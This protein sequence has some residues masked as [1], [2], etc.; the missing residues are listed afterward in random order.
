MATYTRYEYQGKQYHSLYQV[1]QAIWSAEHKVFGQLT[2]DNCESFSVTK[3]QIE[4]PATQVCQP[5]VI[6]RQIKE[7]LM[8]EMLMR[9]NPMAVQALSLSEDTQSYWDYLWQEYNKEDYPVDYHCMTKT[10]FEA[11]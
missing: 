1:R 11:Q 10:E 5:C 8:D 6:K 9:Q 3:V 4:Q 7:K 2:D